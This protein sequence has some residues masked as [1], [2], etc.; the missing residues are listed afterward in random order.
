MKNSKLLML[1]LAVVLI[2]S[3]V[4]GQ[5]ARNQNTEKQHNRDCTSYITDLSETQ[6]AAIKNIQIEKRKTM[7]QLSADLRIKEAELQKLRIEETPSETAINSKIDEISDIKTQI[8]KLDIKAEQDIKKLL[9]ENQR[10]EFDQHVHMRHS[11][12]HHTRNHDC[13]QSHPA[14]QRPNNTQRGNR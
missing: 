5:N 13:K 8:K 11:N 14:K 9:N 7:Q 1:V 12:N 2:S 3:T 10:L 6:E 4:L